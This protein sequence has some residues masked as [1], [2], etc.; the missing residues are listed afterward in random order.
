M[1]VHAL[2]QMTLSRPLAE[3]SDSEHLGTSIYQAHDLAAH[4]DTGEPFAREK[5][6]LSATMP[7]KPNC[8]TGFFK[9]ANSFHGVERV[10]GPAEQRDLIQYSITYRDPTKR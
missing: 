10:A 1:R 8:A 6:S 7:Y 3:T 9:T 2:P 5:F 4:G